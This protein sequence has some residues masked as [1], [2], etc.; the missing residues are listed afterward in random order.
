LTD[1]EN[2]DK[3][4]ENLMEQALYQ[5]VRAGIAGDNMPAATEAL[6]RILQF[7]PTSFHTE[8]AVLFAGQDLAAKGNP[9]AA[10]AVYLRFAERAPESPLMPQVRLAIARTHEEAGD[11]KPAVLEYDSWIERFT[12]SPALLPR[13]EYFRARANFH[14]GQESNAFTQFTNFVA[15][16]EKDE[17]TDRT[18]RMLVPLAL[19]WLGDYHF[20]KGNTLQAEQIYQLLF[21]STNWPKSQLSYQAQIM[22]GRIAMARQGWKD[23]SEYFTNLTSDAKCPEDI[24]AQATLAYGN[25]LVTQSSTN[26]DRAAQVYDSIVERYPTNP[27]AVLALGEKAGCLLQWGATQTPAQFEPAALEFQKLITNK[28]ANATVRGIARIGLAT[29]LEAQAQQKPALE[30]QQLLRRALDTYLDV[31]YYPKDLREGEEAPDAYWIKKAALEAAEVAEKLQDW[32]HAI[33]LYERV[34]DLLPAMRPVV[35]RKIAR[36]QGNWIRTTPGP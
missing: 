1:Y 3:F 28:L 18:A 36:A 20:R 9:A 27:V 35:E 24:W 22:A 23:A 16:F 30:Q 14:A 31:V 32:P 21:K 29:V 17:R 12:N 25:L 33:K 15:R 19:W 10:R 8:G 26:Y 5:K 13:A 34:G 4:R 7:F 11:W 6:N 2:D